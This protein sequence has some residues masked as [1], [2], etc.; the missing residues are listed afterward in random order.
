MQDSITAE[1]PKVKT[2][3]TRYFYKKCTDC[4]SLGY[5]R[6]TME[7]CQSCEGTGQQY[8]GKSVRSV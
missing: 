6:E 7:P 4:H 1:R 3:E 2:V 5:W 8:L